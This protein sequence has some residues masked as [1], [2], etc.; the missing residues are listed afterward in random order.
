MNFYTNKTAYKHHQRA[1]TY[2]HGIHLKIKYF[3]KELLCWFSAIHMVTDTSD[4]LLKIKK[5]IKVF[6][7][8][9]N[10]SWIFDSFEDVCLF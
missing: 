1:K 3:R 2:I 7:A 10:T 8:N 6:S 4:P 5:R 9:L